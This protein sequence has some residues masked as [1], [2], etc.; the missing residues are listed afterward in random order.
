ML[1]LHLNGLNKTAIA[2][3]LHVDRSTV[4]RWMKRYRQEHSLEKKS[5]PGRKRITTEREDVEINLAA[6]RDPSISLETIRKKLDLKC[7]RTTVFR[8]LKE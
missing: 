7:G 5:S 1:E 8:R 6:K 4:S 3:E 2:N